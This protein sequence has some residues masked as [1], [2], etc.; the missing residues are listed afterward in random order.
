MKKCDFH[1]D[2][3]KCLDFIILT[4]KINIEEKRIEIIKIWPKQKSFRDIE[5]FL[6][7]TNIYKNFIKNFIRIIVLL[8]LI[9]QTI[10]NQLVISFK[11]LILAIRIYLMVLGVLKLIML[12]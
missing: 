10:T 11:L 6:K 1:E 3:M 9:L 12:V 8:T 2:E 4:K 7:F 5:V